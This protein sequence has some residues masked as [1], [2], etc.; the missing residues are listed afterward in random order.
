MSLEQVSIAA[1]TATVGYD[2]LRDAE[3]AEAPYR[4]RIVAAGLAGS[5]AALDSEIRLVAGVVDIA[6]M[7]NAQTAANTREAMFRIGEILGPNTRLRAFVVDAPA[8]NPLNLAID[9]QRA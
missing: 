1:A 7:N 9:M 2:L 5:A 8:T 3:F 4:R 6:K